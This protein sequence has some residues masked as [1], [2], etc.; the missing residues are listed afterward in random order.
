MFKLT[1]LKVK[2]V[3]A[4]L[5][6]PAARHTQHAENVAGGF[7]NLRSAW[8]HF[9]V[10][11]GILAD[12][13]IAYAYAEITFF[14]ISP[15]FLSDFENNG[16]VEISE[17]FCVGLAIENKFWIE[18]FLGFGGPPLG[19]RYLWGSLTPKGTSTTS[20]NNP[21]CFACKSDVLCRL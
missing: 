16:T 1:Y 8:R 20:A 6:Q 2:V 21:C 4:T 13:F 11:C 18:N 15:P 19:F 5:L 17:F 14:T 3:S 9:L 10:N 12:R 7:A